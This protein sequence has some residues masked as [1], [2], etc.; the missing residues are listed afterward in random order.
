MTSKLKIT[1]NY[2]AEG[3]FRFPKFLLGIYD[4]TSRGIFLLDSDATG[5]LPTA[6][7]PKGSISCITEPIN[8]SGGVLCNIAVFKG[9]AMNDYVQYAAQFTVET[10]DVY[11]TG[12]IPPRIGYFVC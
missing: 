8:D 12:K 10:E 6:L 3:V 9:A 5:G 1:V 4:Y 2:E 7:P 11:G